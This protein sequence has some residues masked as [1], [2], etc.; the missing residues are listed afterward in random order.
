M[1]HKFSINRLT[2]AFAT[3]LLCAVIS[4]CVTTHIE[5]NINWWSVFKAIGLIAIGF[6]IGFIVLYYLIFISDD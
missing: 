5:F 2:L 6:L 4:S 1:K 3:L